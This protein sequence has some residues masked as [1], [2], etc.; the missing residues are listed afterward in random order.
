[1][2]RFVLTDCRDDLVGVFGSLHPHPGKD[3]P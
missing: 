3:V 1:V 2:T